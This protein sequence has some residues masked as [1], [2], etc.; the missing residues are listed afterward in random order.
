MVTT[1]IAMMKVL[2]ERGIHPDVAA[3]LSLGEYCA[4]AAAGVM[5]EDDAIR[6]VRQRGILMQEEVPAGEGAMAA[7]LALDASVIEEI[8]SSMEAYGL[9]TTTVRARSLFLVRSCGRGGLRALKG[10]RSQESHFTECKR[11]LSLRYA[12]RSRRKAGRG[13]FRSRGKCS[14]DPVCCQRNRRVCDRGS[15][16]KG[17]S[18]PSG[19]FFCKMAA[20][21]RGYAGRWRG[22]LY[23]DW[24]GTYADWLMRK[25][26][27]SVK[28]LNVE[29]LEDIDKVIE[30]LKEN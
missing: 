2:E 3:G 16:G 19:I 18:D 29:K 17:A 23:R 22:Y 21:R 24:T 10:S 1:S 5:S 7:V 20:E 11:S 13:T 15:S 4:L 27:R 28:S 30:A 9:P 12:H 25:I 26:N 8:T 14:Q 6:T